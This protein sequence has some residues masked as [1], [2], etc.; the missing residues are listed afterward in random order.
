MKHASFEDRIVPEFEAAIA[1]L[2]ELLVQ[3]GPALKR[4]DRL[5]SVSQDV[6]QDETVEDETP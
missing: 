2:D 4:F 3:T 6:S 1:V 5:V